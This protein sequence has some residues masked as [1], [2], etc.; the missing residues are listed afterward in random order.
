VAFCALRHASFSGGVGWGWGGG[1]VDEESQREED[2][3]GCE[4]KGHMMLVYQFL[5]CILAWCHC[6]SVG[7]L[8]ER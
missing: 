2:A 7:G 8:A 6:S 3:S 4:V 5:I 1:G